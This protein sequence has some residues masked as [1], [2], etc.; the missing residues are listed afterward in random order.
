[1]GTVTQ[2][3][4]FIYDRV[5][6]ITDD[7]HLL[8]GTLT[9]SHQSLWRAVAYG[10]TSDEDGLCT[11]TDHNSSQ[12][13]RKNVTLRMNINCGNSHDFELVIIIDEYKLII[14]G[15][16]DQFV[17]IFGTNKPTDVQVEVVNFDG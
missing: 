17:Q 15:S 14:S 4:N 5:F 1:M 7:Q 9:M 16:C 3:V 11:F 12:D 6:R 10:E 2:K 13:R 8:F